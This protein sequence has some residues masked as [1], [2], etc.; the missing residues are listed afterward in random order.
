MVGI[1]AGRDAPAMTRSLPLLVVL[2]A[3]AAL[4]PTASAKSCGRGQ[5]PWKV[6]GRTA[7]APAPKPVAGNVAP[8]VAGEWVRGAAA[9]SRRM[10]SRL[11]RAVPKIV[12]AARALTASRAR[13]AAA[14]G[15]EIERVT[16]PTITTKDGT[17]IT[18]SATIKGAHD[19]DL[20]VAATD[21]DGNRAIF[22]PIGEG[23][24]TAPIGCPTA[25][26]VVSVEE[27]LTMGGTWIIAKRKRVLE[28][29]T[30][31]ATATV[32]ARG[33]VGA[34][35]RLRRVDGDLAFTVGE[36]RRGSQVEYTV[37]AALTAGRDGAATISG[38]PSATARVRAAGSSAAEERASE[39]ELARAVARNRAMTGSLAGLV[40]GARDRLLAGEP[41][42][43]DVPNRCVDIR[44]DPEP[45]ARVD[46]D[47]TREVQG[48]IVTAGGEDAAAGA[49]TIARVGRGRF[50][51]VRATSAPGA[52]ALFSATGGEPDAWKETVSADLVAASTAGRAARGWSATGERAAFPW[53]IHGPL[54]STQTALGWKATFD[55]TVTYDLQE[56]TP[57]DANGSVTATYDM[58]AY[59]MPSVFNHMGDGCGF[60]GAGAGRGWTT[61]ALE[62]TRAKDGSV[63]YTLL[64]DVKIEDVP[65]HWVGCEQPE[66]DFAGALQAYLNAAPRP[67]EPGFRLRAVGIT[68][69]TSHNAD[70]VAASWDL[71]PCPD[72]VAAPLTDGCSG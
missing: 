43:Y 69:A 26:G 22:R 5:I 4:A 39:R 63:T 8:L 58:T 42:W 18:A 23:S 30:T 72:P 1:A 35:A 53:R 49:F 68:D 70:A 24:T 48:R 62:L 16:G 38:T 6:A 21:R 20:E 41:A 66:A 46:P 60:E 44:F 7:C 45:G 56:V 61:G 3:F 52:P 13:V 55:G 51:A 32:K 36:Y 47:A 27:S 11:R 15:P 34:D 64:V 50:Q 12:A 19:L 40:D 25:A 33:Q 71:T 54:S 29:A 10:P 14:S 57:P 2:A 9:A 28:S 17:T 37:H 59:D 65:L 67:A 31:R